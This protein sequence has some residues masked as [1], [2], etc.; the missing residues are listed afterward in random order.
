[1]G[2]WIGWLLLTDCWLPL[3]DSWMGTWKWSVV[4]FG[5]V[6]YIDALA[7]S[8]DSIIDDR[9]IVSFILAG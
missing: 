6:D 5:S 1:M 3:V 2:Q 9:V 7:C 8:I 4:F